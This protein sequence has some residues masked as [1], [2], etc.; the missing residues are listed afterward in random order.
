MQMT[1][2]QALAQS[3]KIEGID[4]VFALPGIQMDFFFDALW[5]ERNHFQI[6]HTR[7]EQAVAYMADGFARTTGRIG[8]FVTVP[9]PGVLNATAG[10]STAFSCSSPVFCVTG[11]IDSRAI[12]QGRGALHEIPDQLG[13][14]RHLTKA[15]ER[16]SRPE[17]IPGIVRRLAR[18]LQTG[19]PRPVEIEVAPDVL[20]TV[21]DVTLLEPESWDRAE[22]HQAD[23]ET[24]EAAAK[25]LGEADRPLICAGGGALSSGAWAEIR[26]LADLLEAPVLMTS[27][28]R[29]V[30]SDR[31]YRAQSGRLATQELVPNA[32]VVL[33]IGTRFALAAFLGQQPPIE[34]PGT[35]IH[36]E[37]DPEELGRNRT[38]EIGL[39]GDAKHT[40]SE[41]VRRVGRYNRHRESRMQ[42]LIALREA[43]QRAFDATPLQRDYSAAIREVLPDDGF[44]VS[45]STQV[46][47]VMQGGAFPV[48]EPRT[49]VTSG[50]QGTLG[51]GY[52]TALGVQV[53]N[54]DRKVVSINGDGGFMYNVQELSTQAQQGIPVV[55]IVFND[56]LFGNVRRIQEQRYNGHTLATE[57]KNPDFVQLA[58]LFGVAGYRATTP[59]ELRGVLRE[60][61]DSDAPALIE[62]PMPPTPDLPGMNPMQPLP[63][64]P[65]LDL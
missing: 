35:L 23:D 7:H 56:N 53:G 26:E 58:E 20:A 47:Y 40:A 43:Q 5:E 25:A 48:Y 16:A 64:R 50:Y 49:F 62:V 65:V 30:L 42:E 27:N 41:L 45:E 2:G 60:A 37:I 14:L 9:G 13:L 34:V 32:D 44:L 59:G 54:P 39:L 3:L 24:L 52:A 1:G 33:A 29:G 31:D 57:L 4:T 63:P 6:H 22:L 46:G 55:T 36:A 11:Q 10:L 17:E 21:A 12:D 28:G 8:T 15:A 51:Y 38:P 19:R 18:E 61:L